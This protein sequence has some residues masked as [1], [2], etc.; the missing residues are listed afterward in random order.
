MWNGSGTGG[1]HYEGA[2][3]YIW[4]LE[5]KPDFDVQTRRYQGTVLLLR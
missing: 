4:Q 2:G 1:T 3:M 5:A